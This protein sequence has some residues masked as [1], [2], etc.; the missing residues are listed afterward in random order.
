MKPHPKLG[1]GTS[2]RV[3]LPLAVL[4]L[5]FG[6][7][8]ANLRDISNS[9]FF[10]RPVI[11]GQAYDNWAMAIVSGKAPTQPF[12]QDPL[13]P[14]FLALIYSV[15]GHSYWAV[16]LIQLVLAMVFLLL[17]YDTTR[18][19]FD[20]RAGIAA[21]A[22]IALYKPFIF[23]E[24]Q[25]EK[26]ALAV[27]HTSLLLWLFVLS[28]RSH[29]SSFGIRV[30]YSCCQGQPASPWDSPPSPA[31]TRSCSRPCCCWRWRSSSPRLP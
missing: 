18:R 16:Y 24:S 19:L 25:I 17:I 4:A 28:L 9:P 11:D 20:R 22:M 1:K 6:L 21:A 30:S 14:Y 15:F 7:R 12:F 2:P 27:F 13:Y 10:S 8:V 3:W 29:H 31:P 5:G 26:T 23:Y